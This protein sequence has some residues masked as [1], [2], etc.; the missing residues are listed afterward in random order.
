MMRLRQR[1]SRG[2]IS[3]RDC[4]SEMAALAASQLINSASATQNRIQRFDRLVQ[5][6]EGQ[7]YAYDRDALV[8][9]LDEALSKSPRR[10]H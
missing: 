10:T 8:K 4:L 3:R 2:G 1:H 7:P 9:M 6:N 5:L